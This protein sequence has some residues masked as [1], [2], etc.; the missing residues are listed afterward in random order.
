MSTEE[1]RILVATGNCLDGHHP[2]ALDYVGFDSSERGGAN[3]GAE[4]LSLP[5]TVSK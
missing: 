4:T 2:A 3:A 5:L 1:K